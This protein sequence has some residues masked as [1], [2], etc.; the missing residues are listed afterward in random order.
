[1]AWCRLFCIIL[2]ATGLHAWGVARS[3]LPAQDGLK[4]IR[5]ARAF[6]HQPWDSVV[7]DSDQHPLYPALIALTQPVVSSLTGP[8]PDT[9]RIAAQ[10]VASL[11]SIALTIPLCL[12][13]RTL[14]DARTALLAA[15]LWVLLPLPAEVGHDTLSD[16]LALLAFTTALSLGLHTLRDRSALSAVSCGL[17]SGVGYL[18]RPEVAI[19]PLAVL[20]TAAARW[21]WSAVRRWREDPRPGRVEAT[22]SGLHRSA[23]YPA[24]A[25][26]FLAM[27][28]TY[29][30]IKGEVSEKLALR[31]AAAIPSQ[32]DQARHVPHWLPP[33]LD[34]PRWD[35]SPKEESDA[36][37][38]LSLGESMGRVVYAWAEGLAWG[39]TIL[40]FLG[41][42]RVRASEGR[43]LMSVYV[44][45]FLV[46]LTRHVMML[47]Y[48]SGRHSLSLVIASLP[49]AAAGTLAVGARLGGW[50][51]LS[52][53]GMK[54]LRW[55]ALTLAVLVA[56]AVQSK[57]SHPSRWGHAE[58]GHWLA[59]HASPSDSALDTRG[60][61]AF[62][63]GGSSY[64][65]WHVRQALT[66]ARLAF[67]IV[68]ADEL[69]ADSQRA[70]TL[71]AIVAYACEP[72]IAFPA[73]EGGAG[74]DILVFRYSRP[75]SWEG[76][77]P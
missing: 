48:L 12:V 71:R 18:A 25:V 26:A 41:M 8:G 2:L 60:W 37:G 47:G 39:F 3:T 62:V 50:L 67:L 22:G 72:L 59:E 70:A 23:R 27:I 21:A 40:A 66:D 28:G 7:R 68:G 54:Q 43:D 35:F 9:W 42:I 58:A 74:K 20:V 46:I 38:R 6:H 15:L 1:M 57:S 73:R 63:W 53:D 76:I 56:V 34:D 17:V 5:V 10:A 77:I 11:C 64:D 19:L 24:L 13:A 52:E 61:A 30:L 65:Y 51:N 49:W 31:Q 55:S 45:L 75:D 69:E 44:A 16:P 29:A 32:H 33:G 36:P 14:F 4:F